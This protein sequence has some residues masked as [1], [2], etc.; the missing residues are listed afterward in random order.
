[1]DC[2]QIAAEVGRD[3]KSVWNWLKGSGI[4]TRKRG[5]AA[6]KQFMSGEPSRFKG[7]SH[8]PENR[9]RF[10]QLRIADG[11]VPYLKNG[12]HWLKEDGKKPATWKGGISPERAQFYGTEAWR[13]CV[14][15]VW[16]RDNA[17]CQ[18]CG[19]DSRSVSRSEIRFD[20][21][22]IDGFSVVDRRAIVEN[23]ILI[24]QPCHKWIHSRKNKE[25]VLLGKGH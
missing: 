11:H 19:L 17:E 5:F 9:E 1:M 21:H 7:M 4:K 6:T 24:C 22:H 18:L 8:T 23:L 10:R 16:K 14:S 2:T 20:I 13:T 15:A 25:K 3:P 12:L